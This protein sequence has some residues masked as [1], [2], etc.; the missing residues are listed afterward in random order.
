MECRRCKLDMQP[1]RAAL[2]YVI[3]RVCSEVAG[4]KPTRT[5]VPLHKSNYILV[6]SRDDLLGINNKGGMVR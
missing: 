3:C 6:T 4:P 5:V 1:G 2:G